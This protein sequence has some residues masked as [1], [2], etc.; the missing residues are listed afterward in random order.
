MYKYIGAHTDEVPTY[1]SSLVLPSIEAYCDEARAVKQQGFKAYKIHPPGRD[2]SE[3]IE[4]H[5]AVRKEVGPDF[6]LMSDPVAPYSF[7]E[8]LRLGRELEKLG[9]LWLEEP[10]ADENAAA[11][12][13]LTAALDIPIVG[14]EV[15][16]K[17]PYSLAEYLSTNVVDSIR[18]DVSWSGGVT[19]VLKSAHLAESFGANCE[20]HSTI[21]HPLE[22]VNL[23]LCAAISNN[24]YFELLTPTTKFD[25]GLATP[26]E[27]NQGMAKL[28]EK[29]GLGLELDWSF[30]DNCTIAKV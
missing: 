10:L 9:Y 3:D 30:I 19:G 7:D 2:I 26:I 13:K 25:F 14:T 11:L 29:P 24:S 20:L 23:H 6:T 22:L 18:A 16:A 21:F 12:R 28:P 4:I 27:I 15:L 17:H 1:C 8:A 5:R